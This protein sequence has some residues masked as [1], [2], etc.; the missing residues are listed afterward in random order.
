MR[1]LV[2]L[3]CR[4]EFGWRGTLSCTITPPPEITS[5]QFCGLGATIDAALAGAYQVAMEAGVFDP[6]TGD[7]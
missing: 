2:R 4:V 7:S 5:S 6:I 3:G 1:Y